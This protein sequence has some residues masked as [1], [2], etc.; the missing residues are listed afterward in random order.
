MEALFA[1]KFFSMFCN[2]HEKKDD[3]SKSRFRAVLIQETV[4]ILSTFK[5][6]EHGNIDFT[7]IFF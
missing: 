7:K 4:V 2:K 3:N 6:N 5:K 1:L